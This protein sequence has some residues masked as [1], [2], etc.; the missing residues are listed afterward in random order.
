MSD[1][2]APPSPGAP[3]GDAT[4]CGIEM[5]MYRPFGGATSYAELDAYMDAM[6]AEQALR[7]SGAQ[8][9]ALMQNIMSDDEMEPAAKAAA[10][11]KAAADMRRRMDEMMKPAKKEGLFSRLFSRGDK[12]EWTTAYIN[13]LPD[14]AFAV[15][16]PGGK[17]D[18]EGRTTPR[19]LRHLPHHDADGAIDMPHLRN[20]MA[21][22][23]QTMPAEMRGRAAA[24]L[25]RHASA[26]GMGDRK[27]GAF[28]VFKD[29]SG[30]WRWLAVYSNNLYDREGEVIPLE[31]HKEYVAWAD[32]T[33]GYPELWLWHTPG[34]RVGQAD[35]LDVTSEG[36]AVASGTF[37]ADKQSA[38]KAL[39]AIAD[40]GV[41]HGFSYEDLY[42]GVY[43]GIRTNEISPLPMEAAA[44]QW[45]TFLSQ[46]AA[47][48]FSPEKKEFLSRVLGA[49]AVGLLE[50]QLA[51]ARAKATEQGI[52]FKDVLAALEPAPDPPPPSPAM[53]VAAALTQ[54]MAPLSAKLDSLVTRL[55][56]TDKAVA[57]L[58]AARQTIADLMTPRNGQFIASKADSTVADGRGQDVKAAKDAGVG[59]GASAPAIEGVPEAAKEQFAMLS[60]L[61]N[62]QGAISLGAPAQN[63]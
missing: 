23:N 19:S 6:H 47:S 54:A 27:E 61:F 49:D 56:A 11:E 51:A 60:R 55:D 41:S 31:E 4:K 1:P 35:L 48:M 24:H 10:V 9:S 37:D 52:A 53:D 58:A 45:T 32:A 59:Q 33:R 17:K 12:A 26:E 21:R 44:N 25:K 42:D 50:G 57:D 30:A 14:S 16:E 36:F 34:T 5:G 63:T 22:M 7:E 46:E 38:A 28:R 3:A 29:A 39:A 8:F 40:L 13:S 62:G 18:G 43:R 2:A 20:A 15:I